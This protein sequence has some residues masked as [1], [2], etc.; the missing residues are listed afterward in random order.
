MK[1]TVPWKQLDLL[2]SWVAISFWRGILLH[3]VTD[4][5]VI[6]SSHKPTFWVVLVMTSES[7]NSQFFMFI[8]DN[9]VEVICFDIRC[10][11]HNKVTQWD[12][13]HMLLTIFR[14]SKL[15]YLWFSLQTQCRLFLSSCLHKMWTNR[16]TVYPINVYQSSMLNYKRI[17]SVEYSSTW[18]IVILTRIFFPAGVQLRL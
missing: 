13:N 1:I 4:K 18:N 5:H 15:I 7:T 14:F 8:T 12:L 17:N 2:T 10:K 9:N 3:L 6:Q 16:C 11:L